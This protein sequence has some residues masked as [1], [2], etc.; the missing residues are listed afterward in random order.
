MERCSHAGHETEGRKDGIS[1]HRAI[2]WTIQG[3]TGNAPCRHP[4]SAMAPLFFANAQAFRAWLDAHST[5][6]SELLIGFHKVGSGEPCMHW[7]TKAKREETRSKR[8]A[9]LMQ[10]C[11]AGK[12]L[13]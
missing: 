5:S 6:E 11:A 12:R 2:N 1:A 4:Q 9:Q 7:I 13:A 8:L 10:A 3:I